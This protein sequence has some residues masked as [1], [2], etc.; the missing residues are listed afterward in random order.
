MWPLYYAQTL[1]KVLEEYN[2]RIISTTDAWVLLYSILPIF[3]NIES[4]LKQEKL[5]KL[6]KFISLV[7]PD[8]FNNI[9]IDI[10]LTSYISEDEFKRY[11][12]QFYLEN[13]DLFLNNK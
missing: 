3:I 9:K 10:N 7:N 2:K 5:K 8:I 13:K 1:F 6:D 12:N 11:L 4:D